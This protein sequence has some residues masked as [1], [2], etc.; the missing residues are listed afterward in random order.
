MPRSRSGDDK[1]S[2]VNNILHISFHWANMEND[3]CRG[4]VY[5]TIYGI[6]TTLLLSGHKSGKHIFWKMGVTAPPPPRS[7]LLFI[8]HACLYIH[9][10]AWIPVC[11]FVHVAVG[12][13][14]VCLVLPAA[15]I[16]FSSH[17]FRCSI[18]VIVMGETGCGKTRLIRYMCD[19]ARQGMDRRNMLIMK[20]SMSTIA[21]TSV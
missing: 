17:V 11:V 20:V 7:G 16:C 6:M 18:P 10:S 4:F 9:M 5:R 14:L 8:Y 13:S 19:L 2:S 3:L 1:S 12:V 21:C 15:S